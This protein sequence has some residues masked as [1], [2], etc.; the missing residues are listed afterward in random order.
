M[1]NRAANA[2]IKGYY[3]Q[4]DTTIL[5]FLGLRKAS[6]SVVIE[7]IE[8]IDVNTADK[9]TAIQC[10]YLSKEKLTNSAVREPIILMLDHFIN[11]NASDKMAYTLYAH[12]TSETP[13]EQ[14]NITLENL[15]NILTYKEKKRERV[16]HKEN[17]ISDNKLTSF[18]KVFKL[19][20]AY[21]FDR[22][23]K[24]VVNKLKK[25]FSCSDLE[26][27]T[28]FYNNALRIVLDKA[29]EPNIDNRKVTRKE[30]TNAIDCR[31]K[32]FNEWYIKLRTHE[33][34]IRLIKE[35]IKTSNAFAQTK[36]RYIVIGDDII[37]NQEGTLSL[38]ILIEDLVNKY[39]SLGKIL[40]T[41]KP[42]TFII[43]LDLDKIRKLKERFL[44]KNIMF[45]DGYEHIK[46]SP[47]HFNTFPI[48][49]TTKNG[50]KISTSSYSLKLL[51]LTSLNN[52][53][54]QIDSPDVVI[55]FSNNDCPYQYSE[56]AQVFDV[57]YLAGLTDINKIIG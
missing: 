1:I 32:L 27:D 37:R 41:T 17:N 36:N 48:I 29:K 18:L 13:G 24:Y 43:D 52:N 44:S 14:Y 2:T 38:A 21:E 12:F 16:Y 30:F 15:K 31:K 3:Y 39:Y 42:L 56:A 5:N 51:S 4:F 45:N 40:R 10:K 7:G 11:N 47:S 6:D 34:Y 53:I 26:A 54:T 8:D 20:F 55:N 46:F 9:T 23:Q 25:E 33:K 28:Y 49:N 50:Q 35:Q 19:I 22:Q 57:K